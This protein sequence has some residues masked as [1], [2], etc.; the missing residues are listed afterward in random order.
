MSGEEQAASKDAMSAADDGKEREAMGPG[1]EAPPGDPSAGE[2]LCRTC[3]GSGEADGQSCQACGG[4]G[5]VSTAV[6]GGA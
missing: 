3:N 5:V 1:D 6:S 2:N 4:S